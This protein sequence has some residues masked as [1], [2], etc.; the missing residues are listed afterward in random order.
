MPKDQAA[1]DANASDVPGYA[2]S[3][4]YTYKNAVG[5]KY[6]FGFGLTYKQ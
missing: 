2:E 5:A 3:F 4:D 6:T 1:V